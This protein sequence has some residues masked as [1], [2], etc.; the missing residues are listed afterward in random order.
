MADFHFSVLSGAAPAESG[1]TRL[2]DV[3]DRAVAAAHGA[4][5][6]PARWRARR[7]MWHVVPCGPRGR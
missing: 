1:D 2:A 7:A 3:L 4:A 6:E 5:G